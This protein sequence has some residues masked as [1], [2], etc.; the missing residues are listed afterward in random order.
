MPL[1]QD[2][3]ARVKVRTNATGSLG[4]FTVDESAISAGYRSF[5]QAVTDGDL[6][7]GTDIFPVIVIDATVTNGPKLFQIATCTWN[8]TTKQL[9]VVQNYQPAGPPSWGVGWRDVVVINLPALFMFT[10]GGTMT[11]LV[12]LLLS[13]AA[14]SPGSDTA[15]VAQKSATAGTSA[16]GSIVSG[17]SGIAGLNLG[18]TVSETQGGIR[19]D[20]QTDTLY[21]RSGGSNRT[22]L[23]AAGELKNPSGTR[24]DSF[25]VNTVKMLFYMATADGGWTKD[26]TQNDKAVRVVSGSGGVAGG[27]TRGLS[28]ANVG[29]TTLTVQQIPGHDHPAFGGA[30][31]QSGTGAF[32]QSSFVG[33][34][35]ATGETGGGDPHT[36]AL[37]L[38]FIDVI[39]ATKTS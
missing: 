12:H 11:G 14:I 21:L 2:P 32:A 19:Y 13:G 4:T 23:T 24:Y 27:G 17:T 31:V 37:G 15:L 8:N 6:V 18:D 9:T 3:P 36:H 29:D 5:T 10:T 34:T 35:D 28:A 22:Q 20:N 38:A 7:S 16:Y 30:V 25:T 26:P 1:M 39:I 33:L